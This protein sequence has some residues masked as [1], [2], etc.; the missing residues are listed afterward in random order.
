MACLISPMLYSGRMKT[1]RPCS[2]VVLPAASLPEVLSWY[3]RTAK[4]NVVSDPVGP[5]AALHCAFALL[6][7]VKPTYGSSERPTRLTDEVGP[8]SS[9]ANTGSEPTQGENLDVVAKLTCSGPSIVSSFMVS[10]EGTVQESSDCSEIGTSQN[11]R[12][13]RHTPAHGSR[14]IV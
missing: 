7:D 8:M 3:E 11:P 10:T 9:H 6:L 14:S 13:I 4:L 12:D 2:S 5:V 1:L